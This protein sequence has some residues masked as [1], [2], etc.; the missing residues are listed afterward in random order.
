MSEDVA[1]PHVEGAANDAAIV[2]RLV[3]E[4][5]DRFTATLAAGGAERRVAVHVHAQAGNDLALEVDGWLVRCVVARVG[6]REWWARVGEATTALLW[7]SPLPDPDERGR[8]AGSLAAPMPGQVVSV[9]VTE[10]QAVQAGDPLLI[11]HAMKME[12]LIAAPH[13]GT[14][15]ALHYRAGEAVPAGAPLLEL[16]AGET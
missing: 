14:I 1:S 3:P 8:G 16:R 9:L 13:A 2:V 4:P 6:E 10:G 11:L 15:A 7:R 12:H 5:G